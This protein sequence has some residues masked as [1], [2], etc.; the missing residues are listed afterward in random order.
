MEQKQRIDALGASLLIGFSLLLG[1]NQVLVKLVNDG[2]AP[3]FQGGLR[4][5]CAAVLILIYALIRK[6]DLNFRDGTMGLGVLNGTLF[7]LEFAMLFLAL[8]YTSVARVSLFFYTMPFFVAI[9]AH[10]L[11]PGER[12]TLTRTAGLGLA[13]LGVGMALF[14]NDGGTDQ[15][16]LLGDLLALGAAIAWA[17]IA[18]LTRG[19]RLAKIP[20]E[21]NLLYQLVVSGA[22]LI[23]LALFTG[24]TIREVTPTILGIFTFQVIFVA[25]FG[26]LLW[27][28]ILSIYPVSDMASFSLLTPLSAVFFGWVVFNETL[29]VEF[30]IALLLVVSGL[31]LVNRKPKATPESL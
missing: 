5:A 6:R 21:Q 25:S 22:M 7:G 30:L 20:L 10:F 28:W 14:T 26:F 13:I 2:F 24:E 17:S 27:L 11:F 12:L 18:L 4:S 8:D 31:L 23:G 1:L 29:T 15:G 16:S 9:G 19:T 3:L